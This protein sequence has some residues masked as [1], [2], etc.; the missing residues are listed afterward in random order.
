LR[1]GRPGRFALQAAIAAVHAEAPSWA[2]TD[3]RQVVGLYDLLLQAWPSPVVA[4]N[5]AAAVA[6]RDGPAAG[7]VALDALDAGAVAGYRYLPATRA[8]LLR[9]LG[10]AGEAATA[11][12]QALDLTDN[13]AERA[14]LQ[15]RLAEVGGWPATG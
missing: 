15:R 10:R 5:R 9:R 3:W 8:D 1:G 2:D 13:A 11:Y 7:L 12:R 14:F 4:L 6:M